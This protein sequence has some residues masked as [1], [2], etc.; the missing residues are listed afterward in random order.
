MESSF[1][2]RNICVWMVSHQ[3]YGQKGGIKVIGEGNPSRGK[4]WFGWF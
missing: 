3:S 1:K 2:S 4:K